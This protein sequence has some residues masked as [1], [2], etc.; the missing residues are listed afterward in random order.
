MKFC[1]NLTTYGVKVNKQCPSRTKGN[2]Y[3]PVIL[4]SA[5]CL[6]VE[7]EYDSDSKEVTFRKIEFNSK[8]RIDVSTIVKHLVFC[9]RSLKSCV[10]PWNDVD[11]DIKAGIQVV[12]VCY[13]YKTRVH[14]P[15]IIEDA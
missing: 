5:L 1:Y 6:E 11:L 14:I 4:D 12:A 2:M 9:K 3:R 10:H 7:L 8:Q 15:V 13:Q